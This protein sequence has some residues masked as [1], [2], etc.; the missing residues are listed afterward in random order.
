MK[1]YHI[2]N[3]YK[4]KYCIKKTLSTA[5]F[6]LFSLLLISAQNLS[7][8][9]IQQNSSILQLSSTTV[10]KFYKRLDTP[11]PAWM[12]KQIEYDLLPFNESR[13]SEKYIDEIFNKKTRPLSRIRIIDGSLYVEQNPKAL[14]HVI[15]PKLISFIERLHQ[16]SPLPDCDF[17]ISSDD[18]IDH[19]NE[20][21][22][23]PIFTVAKFKEDLSCILIPDWCALEGY[24]PDLNEVL[25]GNRIYPWDTKKEILFFRGTDT[26]IKD[27]FNFNT[28]KQAPR[29]QLV[30]LSLNY[31]E[32]IDAKL[33]G[34]HNQRF[35][36]QIKQ[37]GFMGSYVSMQE[38][39]LLIAQ[40]E[41][42]WL[43]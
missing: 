40:N 8:D 11:A 29:P 23:L 1:A 3:N 41:K 9:L 31:P 7:A 43:A 38:H 28:W 42:F 34:L 12:T 36:S 16:L 22:P 24:Q 30:S 14:K 17:L 32:L 13:L 18:I 5:I 27:G 20:D 10:S 37:E 21:S 2:S 25:V 4:S 35:Q 26:G 15:T 19:R 33:S 6:C 39:I